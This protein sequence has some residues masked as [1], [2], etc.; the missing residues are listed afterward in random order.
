M[1]QI[2]PAM[3]LSLALSVMIGIAFGSSAAAAGPTNQPVYSCGV[4][5]ETGPIGPADRLILNVCLSVGKDGTG[6][7]T[8]S[9]AVHPGANAHLAVQQFTRQGDV[10]HFSGVVQAAQ[11]AALVGQAFDVIGVE[12]GDITSLALLI[13]GNR[14]SGSGLTIIQI[15]AAQITNKAIQQC[16]I[17]FDSDVNRALLNICLDEA[18]NPGTVP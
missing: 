8:I 18:Q 7:G 2:D 3:G 4:V 14:Y 5:S 12:A 11:D 10:D 15:V 13:D 1:K 17:L 6:A 16:H 9:D